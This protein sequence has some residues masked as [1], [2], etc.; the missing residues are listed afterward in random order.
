MIEACL[1]NVDIFLRNVKFLKNP[2]VKPSNTPIT[3]VV[4]NAKDKGISSQP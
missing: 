1:D 2:T 4:S 3:N